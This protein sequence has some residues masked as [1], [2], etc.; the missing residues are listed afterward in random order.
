MHSDK[1][2]IWSEYYYCSINHVCN[3][4]SVHDPVRCM[5]F[6]AFLVHTLLVSI[7]LFDVLVSETKLHFTTLEIGWE[8]VPS[9][10]ETIVVVWSVQVWTPTN[11]GIPPSCTVELSTVSWIVFIIPVV[12]WEW[13]TIMIDRWPTSLPHPITSCS[14]VHFKI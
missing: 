13:H 8:C 14:T 11:P 5:C 10:H 6:F 1:I 9:I 7:M 3:L 2:W 12:C 4:M